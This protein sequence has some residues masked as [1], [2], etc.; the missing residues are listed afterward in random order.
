MSEEDIRVVELFAGVGGFRLGLEGPPSEEWATEFLEFKETGFNI[1][2]SNQWEPGSKSQWASKIYSERFGNVGHSNE[3]IHDVAFNEEE[4]IDSIRNQIPEFD[5]LVGG[6]PCQDYSVARTVS[7]ELGIR[8]EKGKLWIPIRNIIRHHRPRP[9]VILLENVPRLLNPPAS[10]RGLNFAIIITDLIRL[11][12]EVEWRVINAADYGMPQQR[13]RVFILAYRTPGSSSKIT[14]VNGPEK[15]QITF[16]KTRKNMEKWF[17]RTNNE[18]W[19]VDKH[20]PFSQFFLMNGTLDKSPQI[21]G[22]LKSYSSKKSRFGKAGYAYLHRYGGRNPKP[23]EIRFWTVN[24]EP[25]YEGRRMRVLD[26]LETN[27]DEKYQ[28]DSSRID[29]WNYAKGNKNE[30]RIRKQDRENVDPEVLAA[31]D[32][33]MSAPF[34]KR[35]GLWTQHRHKFLALLGENKFYK[36]DEGTMGLDDVNDPS[37][38]I[39]TAEIG[40]TP[41]RMRHIFEDSPG[42]YRRLSPVETERLNMFPDNWTKIEDTKGRE[43]PDS[44]R[45]FMMGNALVV[46]IISRL[47]DPIRNL[48]RKRSDVD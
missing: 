11:G 43:I 31:Y 9:K 42:R 48:I 39:V 23:Q 33:C 26:I 38:T 2:W 46:G 21:L 28:L 15:F 29:E 19:D 24:G 12:Y 6:F 40:T 1:V 17:F 36:Y 5:L 44:R 35:S 22:D 4:L 47:R 45:G 14:S 25:N 30:F 32:L 18:P 3:D 20:S 8:G 37:R 34:S 7:G 41:S 27:F 16:Q 13:S 10:S